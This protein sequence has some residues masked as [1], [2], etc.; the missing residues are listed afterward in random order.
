MGEGESSDQACAAL[1]AF[2]NAREK[3]PM[4]VP[5]VIGMLQSKANIALVRAIPLPLNGAEDGSL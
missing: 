5:A 2:R 1:D 3:T 4:P